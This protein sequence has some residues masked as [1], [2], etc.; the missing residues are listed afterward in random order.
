ME[1]LD[2]LAGA[3]K[4]RCGLHRVN[5]RNDVDPPVASFHVREALTLSRKRP[6]QRSQIELQCFLSST[7]YRLAFTLGTATLQ[8]HSMPWLDKWTKQ[9]ILYLPY[10][11][12]EKVPPLVQPY[13][14]Q[15]LATSKSTDVATVA[16]PASTVPQSFAPNRTLFTL[17]LVCSQRLSLLRIR[18]ERL[19]SWLEH[20]RIPAEALRARLR[21][22]E[23]SMDFFVSK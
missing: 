10:P 9:D 15:Q 18:L 8:H 17:G 3:D 7:Q 12:V 11:E 2:Y 5:R 6:R 14:S 4:T 21:T 16:S 23:K 20:S 1:Y 19:Q 22:L 13:I